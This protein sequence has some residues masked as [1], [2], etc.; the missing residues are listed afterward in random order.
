MPA[1][2]IN[3]DDLTPALEQHNAMLAA[4]GIRL[5]LE[6][7]GRR[8]NLRGP[9]PCR[10]DPQRLRLQR[11]SLG[12][13]ADAE[14][15]RL[16]HR[17]LLEI[18]AQLEQQRFCWDHWSS[19]PGRRS[20]EASHATALERQLDSFEAAFFNDPRRRRH[21]AGSRTTWTSAYLPYLRRLRR[22]ASS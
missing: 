13:S 22:L 14:G 6:Q 5:R 12:L 4:A 15:L 17:Q 9:L 10:T 1:V 8:L 11:L 21:A 7:R 20:S 16:A 3:N 19:G 18:N 2:G